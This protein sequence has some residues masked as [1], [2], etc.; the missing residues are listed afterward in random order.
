MTRS[1]QES[2]VLVTSTPGLMRRGLETGP[3]VPR[4]SSTLLMRRGLE[5]GQ[6]VP[7][8]SSTLL[9]TAKVLGLTIPPSVL[10]RAD[11]VIQ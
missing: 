2:P 4:Q 6:R 7:R 8:Q 3:L 5:T 9:K 1:E 10:A 11:E